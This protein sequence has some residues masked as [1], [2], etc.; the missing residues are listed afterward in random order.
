M[1]NTFKNRLSHTVTRRKLNMSEEAPVQTIESL[2]QKYSQLATQLGS[3]R[4]Q[5]GI[6]EAEEQNIVLQ[7]REINNEAAKLKAEVKPTLAEAGGTVQ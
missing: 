2:T 3:V 7:M 6:F 4:Y 1:K 5:R